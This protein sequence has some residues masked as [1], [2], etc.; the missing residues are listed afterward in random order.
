MS[1]LKLHL[2]KLNRVAM[3]SSYN[4]LTVTLACSYVRKLLIVCLSRLIA[5]CVK[6]S[7]PEILKI[8]LLSAYLV[9]N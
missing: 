7:H 3:S 6:V 9:I 4:H 2:W 5:F 1:E 8:F